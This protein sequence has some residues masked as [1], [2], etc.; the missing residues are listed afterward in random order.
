MSPPGLRLRIVGT[1][2][3]HAK[4]DME[5]SAMIAEINAIEQLPRKRTLD[6]PEPE[7]L[8][9]SECAGD[10][11]RLGFDTPPKTIKYKKVKRC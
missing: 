9:V 3:W 8:F 7:L 4:I 11:V 1:R 10:D 5:I 6:E 2:S